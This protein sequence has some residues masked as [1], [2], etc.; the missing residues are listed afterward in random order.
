MH[1]IPS[2]PCR[3]H[4]ARNAVAGRPCR[5]ARRPLQSLGSAA[6]VRHGSDSPPSRHRAAARCDIRERGSPRSRAPQ[7]RSAAG[8]RGRAGRNPFDSLLAPW[9]KALKPVLRHT[10]AIVAKTIRLCPDRRRPM[11]TL[12]RWKGRSP[13]FR[14]TDPAPQS[15]NNGWLP[16]PDPNRT[17]RLR[18]CCWRASCGPAHRSCPGPRRASAFQGRFRIDLGPCTAAPMPCWSPRRGAPRLR[19][20]RKSTRRR[21]RPAARSGAGVAQ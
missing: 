8:R 18:S 13:A 19:L 15:R 21:P 14:R 3:R 20:S 16:A 10:Q 17:G 7:P 9:V 1:A 5:L 6:A 12:R 4:P 2:T 11:R